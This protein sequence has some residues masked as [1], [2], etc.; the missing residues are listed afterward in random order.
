MDTVAVSMEALACGKMTGV[1]AGEI[2]S[3]MDEADEDIEI[4]VRNIRM[5][6]KG[7]RALTG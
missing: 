1:S 3:A 6:V 4:P 7:S 2:I 5:K